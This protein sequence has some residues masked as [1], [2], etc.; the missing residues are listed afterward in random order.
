NSQDG[1]ANGAEHADGVALDRGLTARLVLIA[2]LDVLPEDAVGGIDDRRPARELLIDGVERASRAR[3]GSDGLVGEGGGGNA[4]GND[5]CRRA[6]VDVAGDIDG[7]RADRNGSSFETGE[8]AGD[9]RRLAGIAGEEVD[10][11]ERVLHAPDRKGR[12]ELRGEKG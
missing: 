9:D 2:G 12:I 1:S 10:A 4:G 7:E 3:D 8:I 11:P 5:H 6:S